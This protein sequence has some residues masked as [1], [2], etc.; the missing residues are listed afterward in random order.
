MAKKSFQLFLLEGKYSDQELLT[1]LLE[2]WLLASAIAFSKSKSKHNHI[3]VAIFNRKLLK[4][5]ILITK[6]L[7]SSYILKIIAYNLVVMFFGS[8]PST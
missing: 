7:Y 1:E 3:A 5:L 2:I 6:K 4:I 8:I